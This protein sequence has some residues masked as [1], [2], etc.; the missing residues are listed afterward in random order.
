MLR[1]RSNLLSV[2]VCHFSISSARFANRAIIYTSNG[3]PASVL[4]ALT[5]PSLPS[6]PANSLNIKYILAPINPADINVIEGVYPD[7]PAPAKLQGEQEVFVAG[8]EGLG[9]VTAVG[10]G[11]D[12]FEKGEWVVVGKQ[13]CGTWRS[14]ANV[15]VGDVVKVPRGTSEVG[16]ATITVGLSRPHVNWLVMDGMCY[17]GQPGNC[18]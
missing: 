2:R 5:F 4:S 10:S 7:K 14:A 8:N 18:I 16:A 6:P 1:L 17:V 13:Q 12:G 9:E 11:V 3:S 15:G